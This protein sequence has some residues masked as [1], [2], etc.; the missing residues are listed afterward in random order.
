MTAGAW[1][2]LSAT[3]GVVVFFAGRFFWKVLTTP[4]RKDRD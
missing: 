2:M 1:I 3:W 4:Q